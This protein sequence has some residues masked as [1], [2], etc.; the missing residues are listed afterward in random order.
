MNNLNDL[1]RAMINN[2]LQSNPAVR[3]AMPF[4]QGKSPQQL[5]MTARNLCKERGVDV[6]QMY[7]QVQSMLYNQN[8]K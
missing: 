2:M 4:I 5:E 8:R 7:R 1:A 3:Q 6:E